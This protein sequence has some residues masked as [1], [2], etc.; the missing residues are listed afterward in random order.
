MLPSRLVWRQGTALGVPEVPEVEKMMASSSDSGLPSRPFH[1]PSGVSSGVGTTGMASAW[2]TLSAASY[3]SSATK[4]ACTSSIVIV[5]TRFAT[6]V[7]TL[8]VATAPPRRQQAIVSASSIGEF[9][10]STAIRWPLAK[11][12]RWSLASQ[13]SAR[14]ESR[15]QF[16]HCPCHQMQSCSSLPFQANSRAFSS[17]EIPLR[18]TAIQV[19]LIYFLSGIFMIITLKKYYSLLPGTTRF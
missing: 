6:P 13:S 4:T 5:S 10:S 19:H 8:S 16:H 15:R 18:L 17:L 11:P 12:A 7:R 14:A 3:F 1:S 2:L 9:G